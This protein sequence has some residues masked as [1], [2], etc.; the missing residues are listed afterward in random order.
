[1]KHPTLVISNIC[2]CISLIAGLLS[3]KRFDVIFRILMA[4]LLLGLI[5]QLVGSFSNKY[6]HSNTAVYNGYIF[7]E[8]WLIGL[9]GLRMIHEKLLRTILLTAMVMCALV[10]VLSMWSTGIH[11]L[12]N[13]GYICASIL[14]TITFLF[15]VVKMTFA[16]ESSL[17]IK[18]PKFWLALGILIYYGCTVPIFGF[19]NYLLHY[20]RAIAAKVYYI[21]DL[22]SIVRYLF[23]FVAILL[24]RGR[25]QNSTTVKPVDS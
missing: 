11:V 12:A 9:L 5:A 24:V 4:Q 22:L 10:D 16:D 2:L 18:S 1:M 25:N 13:W 3:W 23:M 19:F 20:H 17:L 14:F 15:I 21:N 6:Y 8:L 7:L